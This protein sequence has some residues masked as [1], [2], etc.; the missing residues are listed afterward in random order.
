[1]KRNKFEIYENGK[2]IKGFWVK[3]EFV[4]LTGKSV[5]S[6]FPEFSGRNITDVVISKKIKYVFIGNAMCCWICDKGRWIQKWSQPYA[7]ME[8]R[9]QLIYDTLHP[10]YWDDK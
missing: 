6:V 10:D 7:L 5:N 2:E 8:W 9:A 4:H 1:M 3:P